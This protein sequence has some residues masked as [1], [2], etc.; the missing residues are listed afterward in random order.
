MAP[1]CRSGVRGAAPSS[2]VT[3]ESLEQQLQGD[4][5]TVAH[6]PQTAAPLSAAVMAAESSRYSSPERSRVVERLPPPPPVRLRR[7]PGRYAMT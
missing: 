2:P 3:P 6:M 5:P 7:A 1:S 4:I